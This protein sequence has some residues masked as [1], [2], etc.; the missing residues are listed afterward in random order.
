MLTRSPANMVGKSLATRTWYLIAGNAKRHAGDVATD[1]LLCRNLEHC[2][3]RT[4]SKSYSA[5]S[6]ETLTRAQ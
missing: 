1:W 3:L 6:M 5:V 4:M 2:G